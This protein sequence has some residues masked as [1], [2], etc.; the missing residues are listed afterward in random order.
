MRSPYSSH[1]PITKSKT[2]FITSLTALN[3]VSVVSLIHCHIASP[4]SLNH[5]TLLYAS[6][7]AAPIATIAPIIKVTGENNTPNTV[8]NAVKPAI[9]DGINPIK[10]N[11]G[12]TTS[13]SAAAMPA[14]TAIVVLVSSDKLLNQSTAF[15]I[16]SVITFTSG[17]NASPIEIAAPSSPED[18]TN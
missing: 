5:S 11:I 7:N 10:S 1:K 15:C 13:A 2:E 8:P 9:I 6:T 16:H 12:P 14:T 4:P 3:T 18:R 17:N